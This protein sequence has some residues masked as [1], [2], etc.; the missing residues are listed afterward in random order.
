MPRRRAENKGKPRRPRSAYNY[1][2]HEERNRI[3]EEVAQGVQPNPVLGDLSKFIASRWK[4]VDDRGKSR[5]QELAA[6]DKRRY[7]LEVVKWHQWQRQE[8]QESQHSHSDEDKSDGNEG[9]P[10][11]DIAETNVS[12]QPLLHL[13]SRPFPSALQA[14]GNQFQLPGY[15]LHYQRE[16]LQR[17]GSE[18]QFEDTVVEMGNSVA[19]SGQSNG[20]SMAQ[21]THLRLPALGQQQRQYQQQ[22]QQQQ[23]YQSNLGSLAW[24]AQELGE[25]GVRYFVNLFREDANKIYTNDS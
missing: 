20:L 14:N 22:Q 5:Y 4:Q 11:K 13:P 3:L 15:P 24:V 21:A 18:L 12:Q 23:Q 6:K 9:S 16:F 17:D 25:D 1:F 2:F 8:H 10:D 19:L 7:A